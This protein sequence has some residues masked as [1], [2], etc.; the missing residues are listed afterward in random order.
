MVEV[1][2]DLRAEHEVIVAGEVLALLQRRQGVEHVG[3]HRHRPDPLSLRHLFDPAGEVAADVKQTGEKIDIVPAQGQQLAL[4]QAGES[5]DLVEGGVLRALGSRRQP[6][7]LVAVE[8]VELAGV[9][10]LG[11]S[12][13]SADAGWG[14]RPA[15]KPAWPA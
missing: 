7:Y 6:L 3:H 13:T 15:P 10:D 9:D 11:R 8:G 2:A 4:A 5:G 14:S 12:T 1:L